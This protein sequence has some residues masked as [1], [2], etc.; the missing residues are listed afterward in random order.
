MKIAAVLLAAGLSRRYGAVKLLDEIGGKKMYRYALELL[1]TLAVEE[2]VVV[3]GYEEIKKAAEAA[4]ISAVWNDKPELGISHSLKLGLKSA[5]NSA[6]DLDGA[7]FLVCDQPYL[8]PATVKEMLA[9]FSESDKEILCP[10]PAGGSLEEAGN[11]CIIGKKYFKELFLLE[12][13]IGGKRVIRRHPEDVGL[14]FVTEKRELSDIDKK[15]NV[16]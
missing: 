15:I 16:T 5:L 9:A 12:G 1:E 13:D 7:L 8:T 6:P 3:T 11:P 14:Y 2:K 10:A 4:G